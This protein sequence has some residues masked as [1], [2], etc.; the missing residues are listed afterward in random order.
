M[1]VVHGMP[2]RLLMGACATALIVATSLSFPTAPAAERIDEIITASVKTAPVPMPAEPAAMPAPLGSDAFD[3]ALELVSTG[4]YAD[5][6]DAARALPND[7]ERRVVQWAAIYY[8]NGAIPYDSVKRFEQDAPDFVTASVFKTRLEQALTKSGASGETLISVLGGT[9]PKT[10]AAQIGLAQ[11]YVA[12]GKTDRAAAIARNIWINDYLDAK[13]EQKVLDSLGQLLTAKDH[14]AR[15][16][17]LMMNDRASGVERLFAYMTPAQKSL[18]VARNAVSRNDKNAK[19]LLDKVDPAM[20][21]NPIYYFS[22]AERARQFQLWDDAI[23]YLN[24]GKASDPDPEKWWY[25]RRTLI[26]QLLSVGD[27]QRAYKA[28]AD[29]TSGPE[30]RLVE[31]R[32]HAGWIALSFLREPKAAIRH[33]EAEAKLSTLPDSV[34]QANYWLGRARA[35][36]GDSKG[37]R[38]AY[39]IAADYGTIYYG[40]LARAEL[41]MKP[42]ELRAMPSTKDAEASFDNRDLVQAINL[43]VADKQND[44]AGVLLRKLA[45]DDLKDGGE[46][47]LAARL[48]QKIDAHHLAIT[49]ADIA[50]KRGMPLDLF[51]FPKD[52]LPTTKLADI[53]MAA[54]YAITRTES[55]FQT[56][57][58]SSSGA[59]GLMQLMPGTAKETA[60]KIGVAYSPRKLT[61]DPEYNTQLGSSYLAAQLKTYDG[62]LLLAAAAYNAGAGNANKWIAAY[63]DPRASNVDPVVWV[64]LIPF[65]ETRK[66]VQ[67]VVG[68]YL[69]YRARLGGSAISPITALHSIGG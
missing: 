40:L 14:W 58:V 19:A 26:R 65:Q 57:A 60:K 5:A 68:N 49:I 53:D 69:V 47:V 54:I 45:Q 33:F 67:R 25:E 66:Y 8:G 62:S 9:M 16:E 35:A 27:A 42:V 51:S 3:A 21:S 10:L 41:G 31:A 46:F 44:M 56:D 64:E 63:G 32:F 17:H 48:A 7:I 61:S 23:A 11:A 37:A 2:T 15:A 6:Y 12:A 52:G 43:L 36:A 13:T 29:Y 18:A 50:D 59:L 1:F 30:G 22:R 24:K 55:R 20:Q 38:A 4:K 34:T 28:A 39:Q